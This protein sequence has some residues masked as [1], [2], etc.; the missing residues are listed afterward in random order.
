MRQFTRT[1]RAHGL[2]S[3]LCTAHKTVLRRNHIY[4]LQPERV[5]GTPTI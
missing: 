3:G 4:N 1:G 5:K 2:A